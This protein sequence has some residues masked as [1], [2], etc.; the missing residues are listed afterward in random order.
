M[1]NNA[2]IIQILLHNYR[3]RSW[4]LYRKKN[5]MV[6]G[7]FNLYQLLFHVVTILNLSHSIR[8][9][10]FK[11]VSKHTNIY[12]GFGSTNVDSDG[13]KLPNLQADDAMC[14]CGSRI[15]YQNCCK[16]D[17]LSLSPSDPSSL[18][19]SRYSAYASDN[20]DYIM[21]TTSKLSPDYISF[22]DTPIAPQNG[23]KRWA[24]NIRSTMTNDY[25]YTRYEIDS[26]DSTSESPHTIVT[27]RHLAIRKVDNVMYPI[28]ESSVLEKVEDKWFYIKGNV[29]RPNENEISDMTSSWP[30]LVGLELKE[31]NINNLGENERSLSKKLGSSALSKDGLQRGQANSIKL[32]Q[33]IKNSSSNTKKG[34]K[35]I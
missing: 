15:I 32:N 6:L 27:W 2:P 30:A 14:L 16:N 17:H 22:I 29:S 11:V 34:T 19:R 25:I 18:I 35:K 33:N 5:K 1:N 3:F 7:N 31:R 23:M 9:G 8:L 21:T 24:R 10:K 20:V 28:K 4:T 26:I 12:A 13:K